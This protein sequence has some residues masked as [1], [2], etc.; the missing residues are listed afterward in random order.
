MV[1]TCSIDGCQRGWVDDKFRG[2]SFP[3][4]KR[5]D[6]LDT[7][8]KFVGKKNWIP[9]K[10]SALCYEH[11]QPSCVIRGVSRWTLNWKVDPV[12][13]LY[14]PEVISPQKRKCGITAENSL[15]NKVPLIVKFKELSSDHSPQGFQFRRRE[16]DVIFYNLYFDEVTGFPAI[17]E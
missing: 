8:I 11:F 17:H 5:Q 4:K 10:H 12:P 6:I 15:K 14:P 2:F 13:T 9:N 3:F 7:W 16:N 1:N